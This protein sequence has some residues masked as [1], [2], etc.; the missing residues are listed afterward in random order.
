MRGFHAGVEGSVTRQVDYRAMVSHRISYGDSYIPRLKKAHDTSWMVEAQWRPLSVPG[1]TVK[2][3]VAIDSG[4]MYGDNFGA[5]LSI[6]YRG[7]LN[8]R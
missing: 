7:V 2:A 4:D 1:L 8:L 6:S 5:M 3:Q